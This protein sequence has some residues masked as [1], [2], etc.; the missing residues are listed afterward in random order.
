MACP[1]APS[2]HPKPHPLPLA[3]PPSNRTTLREKTNLT[4]PHLPPDLGSN[5][6]LRDAMPSSSLPRFSRDQQDEATIHSETRCPKA[7]SLDSVR[8]ATHLQTI[9]ILNTHHPTPNR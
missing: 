2:H 3:P 1:Q 6:S 4:F 8:R 5:D 7:A 9:S